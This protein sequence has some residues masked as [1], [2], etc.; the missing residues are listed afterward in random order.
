MYISN[1]STETHWCEPAAGMP[2]RTELRPLP[3]EADMVLLEVVELLVKQDPLRD[4][5]KLEEK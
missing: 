3:K 4:S 5:V 2:R 1:S